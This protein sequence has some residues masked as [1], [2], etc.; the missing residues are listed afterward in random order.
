MVSVIIT[1]HLNE[2]QK[3]LDL[4]LKSLELQTGIDKEVVVVAGTPNKPEVPDWVKLEWTT[5]QTPYAKKMN[6]GVRVSNPHNK[7]LLTG[8]DDLIFGKDSLKNLCSIADNCAIILNP[9]SNCDNHW[10]YE[11]D[12]KVKNALS[13]LTLERFM[14]YDQIKGFERAIMEMPP[15]PKVMHPVR[16]NCLYASLIPR[17]VWNILGGLDE[18]Y[19]N[20][21]EDTDFCERGRQ[22]GL[23]CFVT[24]HAFVFHFG[25]AT[26]NKVHLDKN[27]EN[28][29]RFEQKFGYSLR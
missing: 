26:T 2:N 6:H 13:E 8:Q 25:G 7:Y 5:E 15:G 3:Y 24:S 17:Q 16:H 14:T 9:L 29:R 18:G 23:N 12:F 21:V 19:V 28:F 10:L 20:G 22:Q 1:T 27:D 11:G 4:C